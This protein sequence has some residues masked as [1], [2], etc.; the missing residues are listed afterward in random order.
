MGRLR[1]DQ[2]G[3]RFPRVAG[4]DNTLPPAEAQ[5]EW[6]RKTKISQMAGLLH[7]LYDCYDD[8]DFDAEPFNT[9]DNDD[10]SLGRDIFDFIDTYPDLKSSDVFL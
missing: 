9:Y 10:V 3:R 2:E 1:Y 6:I 7:N 4:Y 8:Q 5:A